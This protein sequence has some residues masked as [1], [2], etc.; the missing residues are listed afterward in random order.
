MQIFA[1]YTILFG[2]PYFHHPNVLTKI[3]VFFQLVLPR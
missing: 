3:H 1:Q 2:G